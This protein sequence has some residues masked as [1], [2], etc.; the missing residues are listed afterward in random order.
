MFARLFENRWVAGE[1]RLTTPEQVRSCVGHE[2]RLPPRPGVRY[3]LGLDVGLVNDRTVLTVAHGERRDDA[4][5][6]VV[7]HQEVWQGTKVNPV[8]LS[9][10]EAVCRETL[11]QYPGRLIFDPWQSVHLAQRLRANG[12]RVGE[13]TFSSASVGRLALCLYRLLRDRLLDLPD[14]DDLV[15]EL[16]SVVL[17]E[18]QPGSYRIDTTGEGHDDRV[19]SLALVAQKLVSQSTSV[20]R[21]ELAEGRVP[22]TR[23]PSTVPP[24]L[25]GPRVVREGEDPERL[26]GPVRLGRRFR[27]PPHLQPYYTPPG[28][29]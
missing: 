22:S 10:V 28:W 23:P 3:V 14:D 25:A 11:R 26:R 12:V 4:V 19:I 24:A 15:D 16:S 1:D 13:F 27:I 29:R 20:P 9:D 7:D 8:D 2:G 6:V 5:V 18:N 21:L 17:R